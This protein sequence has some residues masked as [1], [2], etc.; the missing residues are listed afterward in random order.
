MGS[1]FEGANKVGPRSFFDGS[2][3][4]GS[5]IAS[6]CNLYANIGR[7]SSIAPF[8]HSAIGVHPYKYPFASTCPM[9]FSTMKQ[10]GKTFS[11][12][13][14]FNEI[15]P[16][17]VIGNDC[18][19][20]ENV[21]IAGGVTIGDGAVIFA[22]AVVVKDVPPYAIVSGI[23]ANIIGYRYDDD[24]IHYLLKIQWWNRDLEWIEKNYGLLCNIDKLKAQE[25]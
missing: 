2:M 4:Y 22:G 13:N 20:C 7:F 15:V 19:V 17:P 14:T 23:P 10:N 12:I 21:F 11:E 5:Y 25:S 24:T 3:G 16:K 9:F 18:W 6:D 1:N 8:V